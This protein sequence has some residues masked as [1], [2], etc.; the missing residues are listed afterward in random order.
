[1]QDFIPNKSFKVSNTND[2]QIWYK[3]VKG[4]LIGLDCYSKR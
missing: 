1:M 2:M 3:N 4:E